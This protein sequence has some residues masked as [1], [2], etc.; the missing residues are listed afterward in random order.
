MYVYRAKIRSVYDADTLRVDID[1]GF[2][3]GLVNR[4]VR[5]YGIN[6]P[7]MR[8]PEKPKGK[9]SRDWVRKTLKGARIVL[10]V[11]KLEGK[12]GRPIVTV[13]YTHDEED[14]KPV[15][16][17]PMDWIN[18]NRQLVLKKLAKPADYD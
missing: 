18:L 1:L 6:A 10:H 5:L 15:E 8:G 2:S 12:Y 14:Q 9:Q 11:H 7:E 13:Y 16:E 3:V 4:S 17:A